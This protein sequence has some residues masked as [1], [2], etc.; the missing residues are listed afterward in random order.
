MIAR[1]ATLSLIVTISFSTHLL[2]QDQTTGQTT[3][4][5]TSHARGPF[6]VKIA[7]LKSE[8]SL[9]PAFRRMSIDKQLHGDI[10]GT[11]KGEMLTAGTSVKE[12]GVYVAIERVSGT[13]NARKGTFLLHHTGI[14]NRGK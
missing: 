8:D 14:M 13:V 7:P 12:S 2:S 4:P 5:M 1:L 11:S 3:T 10:E 9:D 6:D